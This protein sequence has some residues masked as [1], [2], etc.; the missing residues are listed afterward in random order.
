MFSDLKKYET[1]I[2][3]H[4]SIFFVKEKSH[5]ILFFFYGLKSTTVLS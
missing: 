4:T 5:E 1:N 2:Q 3:P